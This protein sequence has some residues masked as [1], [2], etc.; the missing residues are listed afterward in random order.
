VVQA[1]NP[2]YLGVR[3]L[4]YCSSRVAWGKCLGDPIKEWLGAVAYTYDPQLHREAQI[5]GLQ[6]RLVWV[7]L[8]WYSTCLQ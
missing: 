3:D 4:E 2:S 7:W 6:S 8:K 5:E 1:Y